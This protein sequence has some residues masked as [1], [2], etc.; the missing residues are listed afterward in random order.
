[1]EQLQALF[2]SELPF[3][4]LLPLSEE[5]KKLFAVFCGF[6]HNR[7]FAASHSRGKKTAALESKSRTGTRQTKDTHNLKW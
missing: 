3:V 5:I 7:P 2:T 6:S 4:D 1:M